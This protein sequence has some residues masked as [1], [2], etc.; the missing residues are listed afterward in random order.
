MKL[1]QL[2]QIM[3]SMTWSPLTKKK[4]D[5]YLKD[6]LQNPIIARLRGLDQEIRVINFKYSNNT[7]SRDDSLDKVI[8]N[9]D[10]YVSTV[11]KILKMNADYIGTIEKA[12]L[13]KL[14]IKEVE[15]LLNKPDG[16]NL[17]KDKE[18]II[19][20]LIK[21]AK[22]LVINSIIKKNMTNSL[23]IQ[24]NLKCQESLKA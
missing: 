22:K 19:N 23:R 2:H 1:K 8:N 13:K 21:K 10:S 20:K 16:I 7:L 9:S 17:R 5:S 12:K 4:S 18:E 3:I 11:Y 6:G 15:E 14:I 24:M